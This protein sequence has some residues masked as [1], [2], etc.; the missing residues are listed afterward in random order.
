[1]PSQQSIFQLCHGEKK[2]LFNEMMISLLY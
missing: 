1:M 2:L